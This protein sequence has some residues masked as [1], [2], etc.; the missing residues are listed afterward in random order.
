MSAKLPTEELK[1]RNYYERTAEHYD[2]MHVDPA[3][4]HSKALNTFMALAEIAGPVDSVLDVGAGT[5]RALNKLKE[6]WPDTKVIGIEPVDALRAVGHKNGISK[7][8]LVFGDALDLQFNDNSFD[9]VIETAALHHIAKPSI[10]VKEMARVAK[11]GIMISDCNNIGQGSAWSR[12]SKYLIKS[13]GLWPIFIWI[14]TRGKMCKTSEGDGVFYSFS[15]YDCIDEFRSKFPLI[16][17]MNTVQCA[18]FNIYRGAAHVMIFATNSPQEVSGH[19][20]PRM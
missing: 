12:A 5:G 7:K 18:G 10:A 2:L 13:T 16:H 8:E 20:T 15:A 9:Y 1:Q 11:K 3:D 17:Y 6:R 19:S 4:E 14:Q